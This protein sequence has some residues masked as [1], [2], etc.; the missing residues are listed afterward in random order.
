LYENINIR[1]LLK[2]CVYFEISVTVLG[3]ESISGGSFTTY[4]VR[5]TDDEVPTSDYA[6]LYEIH[7]LKTAS[8]NLS[9]LPK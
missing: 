5:L 6:L 4:V 2:Y 8:G 7:R 1:K 3:L 9:L